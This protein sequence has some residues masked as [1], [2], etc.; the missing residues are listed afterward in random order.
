VDL[1]VDGERVRD[2]IVARVAPTRRR[3]THLEVLAERVTLPGEPARTRDENG[4]R[5]PPN[6]AMAMDQHQRETESSSYSELTDEL[7]ERLITEKDRDPDV[8]SVTDI[9]HLQRAQA[10]WE[11]SWRLYTD[12]LAFQAHLWGRFRDMVKVYFGALG[13]LGLALR[14]GFDGWNESPPGSVLGVGILV[15]ARFLLLLNVGCC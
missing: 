9:S 4:A 10:V 8:P 7:S 11:V 12:E 14:H 5:A 1:V 6:V 2:W 13:V 3:S 15:L